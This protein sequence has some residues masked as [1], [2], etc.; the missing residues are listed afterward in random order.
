MTPALATNTAPAGAAKTLLLAPPSIAR[1]EDRLAAAAAGHERAS[2]EIQMLDRLAAGIVT[3]PPARYDLIRIL[4]DADGSGVEATRLLD[5]PLIH[6]LADALM[7]RGRLEGQDGRLFH[8]T[9][10]PVYREAI[11]AGLL[12]EEGQLVKPECSASEAVPLRGLARPKATSGPRSDTQTLE[13]VLKFDETTSA[14]LQEPPPRPVGVGFVTAGDG[15]EN[16]SLSSED[17]EELIDEDTLLTEEELKRPV[18]IRTYS[19]LTHVDRAL[20]LR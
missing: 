17:D 1:H 18:N 13:G 2:L 4:S 5:R 12:P 10:S 15:L 11:L 14:N 9:V 8:D 3:L 20:S 16:D 19:V 6:M 7:P